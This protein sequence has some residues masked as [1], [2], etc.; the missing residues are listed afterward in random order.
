[1]KKLILAMIMLL[2]FASAQLTRTVTAT[3][4]RADGSP[5][6]NAQ[7]LCVLNSPS[8]TPGQTVAVSSVSART[9][10]SGVVTMTLV[11][12]Q[13]GDN[14]TFY[15][16]TIPS[17]TG[18]TRLSPIRIPQ[19]STPLNLIAAFNASGN[20]LL[21]KF[22]TIYEALYDDLS[23]NGIPGPVGP[24]G[25]TG[26]QGATGPAGPQG[27]IGATGAIGPTGPIGLTGPQGPIGLTGLTGPTGSTGPTGP[28]GN[29]GPAG[30]ANTLSVGTVTTGAA[31]SSVS[32]TITGTSPS[33]TLNLTIP[34][35]DTGATGATGPAGPTGATGP[36]GP[37][38]LTGLTGP[39]GPTGLTGPQGPTGNTGPQGPQGDTGPAGPTGPAGTT[40]WSELT[41]T[42]ATFPPNVDV[43]IFTT[44]GSNTW[45]E[46]P[47]VSSC[48]ITL[49][50]GGGGGGSGR[51]GPAAAIRAAGGGGGG[52]GWGA[53]QR[54][55]FRPLCLEPQKQSQSV[56]GVVVEQARQPTAQTE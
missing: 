24:A 46:Q 26:P 15:T 5:W 22:D 16:C 13:A 4:V 23:A 56:Q 39:Q 44:P 33:Q 41:G 40:L 8:F 20:P 38:G 49:I 43:Q 3:F 53:G 35:G 14:D 29:T 6:V 30:P 42:P 7:V 11:A 52:G 21:P 19:G 47:W 45:T 37:I 10:A 32:A 27:P 36:Q 1:M 9:N 51:K 54:L 25:P 31:G 2:S 18:G 28:T 17:V 50:G 12:N 55:R 34:R 48:T